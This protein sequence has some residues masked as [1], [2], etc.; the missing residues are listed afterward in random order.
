MAYNNYARAQ[1][2]EN[3][4]SMPDYATALKIYNARKPYIKGKC[5]GERPLGKNRN[6]CRSRIELDKD[7]NIRVKHWQTDIITYR[8]N[9][10]ITLQTGGWSSISTAQ[11]MQELLGVNRICRVHCKIYYRHD[12][13]F[14]YLS[15]GLHIEPDGSPLY[16]NDEY[17]HKPQSEV[18]KKYRKQYAFFLEYAKQVLTMSSDFKVGTIDNNSN[19]PIFEGET[20]KEWYMAPLLNTSNRH[21][22]KARDRARDSLFGYLD[23]LSDKAEE[24]RLQAMYELLAPVTYMMGA[25]HYRYLTGVVQWECNYAQ[26]KRGFENL[27]KHQYGSEIFEF[28]LASKK[29][30]VRDVNAKYMRTY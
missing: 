12:N 16:M 9:G 3:L 17:V 2:G 24:D 25:N 15:N 4:D 27:L 28:E 5:K 29:A 11:I 10:D 19:C 23:S 21:N 13:Q 14:H 30:P 6:H 7:G 1:M 20:L 26:F 8:P 22:I 18:M